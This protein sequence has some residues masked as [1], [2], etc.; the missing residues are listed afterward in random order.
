[1]SNI[2]SIIIEVES[3]KPID[4]DGG[5]IKEFLVN[6]TDTE[7]REKDI[8]EFE[9]NF[10]F[11]VA[12]DVGVRKLRIEGWCKNYLNP[13]SVRDIVDRLKSVSDVI[14]IRI[15][16]EESG[17]NIYEDYHWKDGDMFVEKRSFSSE[18]Y[19]LLENSVADVLEISPDVIWDYLE[20]KDYTDILD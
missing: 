20:G 10:I 19:I 8:L 3:S 13:N 12:F 4:E 5:L 17:C 2:C 14:E 9:D 11:D 15:T 16:I 7:T 18:D 6:G 1:M